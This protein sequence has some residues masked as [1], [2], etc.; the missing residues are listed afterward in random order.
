MTS[1]KKKR[2]AI[3]LKSIHD[4]TSRLSKGQARKALSQ[5]FH[6]DKNLIGFSKHGRKQMRD[7]NLSTVDVVNVLH[8]GQILE[9]P[10]YENESWRYRVETSNIT[11][12]IAFRKPHHLV[13]VTAWRNK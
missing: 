11:V 12:I 4:V 7:R 2:N 8:A 5:I 3:D 9:N 6:Y 1:Q 10:E 13:V